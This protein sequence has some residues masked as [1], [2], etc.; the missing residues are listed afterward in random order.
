MFENRKQINSVGKACP[1]PVIEARNALKEVNQIESLVDNEIAV[2]NLEKLAK[3]LALRCESK[4]DQGGIFHV[5]LSKEALVL[6]EEEL[7][8]EAV[9]G[10]PYNVI[11]NSDV[12]GEGAAELGQKLMQTFLFTLAQ[13]DVLP[14]NILFYNRGVFLTCADSPVLKE[15]KTLADAG[16]QLASCGVCLNYY[17]KTEDLAVGEITNMYRIVEAMHEYPRVIQL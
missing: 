9:A 11:I 5:F 14:K 10:T 2:Q 12:M 7:E 16:V 3:Q 4:Q 1:L 6:P 17:E 15:L 13:Q 8:V